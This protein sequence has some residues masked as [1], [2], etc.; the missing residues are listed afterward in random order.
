MRI[1]NRV[2]KITET[3]DKVETHISERIVE[4][5]EYH[6]PQILAVAPKQ[7]KSNVPAFE[8]QCNICTQKFDICDSP[9]HRCP[10]CGSGDVSLV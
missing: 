8:V 1:I 5:D 7:K 4:N 6:M 10:A 2:T 9:N 3:K